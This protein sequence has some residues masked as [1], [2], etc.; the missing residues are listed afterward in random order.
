MSRSRPSS[1]QGGATP[2]EP[3]AASAAEPAGDA[4]RPGAAKVESFESAAERL[5]AIVAELESGEL[6]LE[7]SLRLF[8]EGIKLA[9]AAQKRLDEAEQKVEELLGTDAAGEPVTR[10]FEG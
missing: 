10:D 2:E 1:G 4:E 6:P 3:S 8:E 7:Q 5:G 9:R